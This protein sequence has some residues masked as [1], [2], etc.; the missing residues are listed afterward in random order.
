MYIVTGPLWLPQPDGRGTGKW[1][2]KHPMIGES[3]GGGGVLE[4]GE[5]KGEG[6]MGRV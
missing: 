6:G 1:E 2:M 3:A 5:M 4:E